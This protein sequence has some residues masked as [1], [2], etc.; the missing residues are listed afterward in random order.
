MAA[1]GS[2]FP[3]V[4]HNRCGVRGRRLSNGDFYKFQNQYEDVK[5]K[6]CTGTD[7]KAAQID[8][9]NAM[10]GLS[11]IEDQHAE[12]FTDSQIADAP[13]ARK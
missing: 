12:D 10:S 6:I 9:T 11:D 3:L 5:R 8:L 1:F 4:G 7:V 13:V 2:P